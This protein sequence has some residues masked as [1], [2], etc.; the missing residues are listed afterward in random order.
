MSRWLAVFLIVAAGCAEAS[1]SGSSSPETGVLCSDSWY[2]S[3]EAK[4][5]T[6]DSHGHGPDIGSDEW[7]SVLEFKLGIRD[8][9][10][11]PS[12]DSQ[13]WCRYIDQM[14]RARGTSSTSGRH[15]G[16]AT[17]ARGPSYTC[18]GVKAGSI[19]AM[20][21]E[22]REWSVLDRKLS[23]VYAAA[24]KKAIHEYPPQLKAEQRGWIK[25]RNEC[26]KRDDK[27][28]CVLDA[29]FALPPW[30]AFI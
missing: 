7:K 6:G 19:E 17:M 4:V 23:G 20:I 13:T 28:G 25:G 22:D 9:P 3:I 24:S 11:L 8:K 27:H 18:D 14:V 26:W 1:K 12:R 5:P 10:N 15:L 2:R 30:M 29:Y 16:G 21:C